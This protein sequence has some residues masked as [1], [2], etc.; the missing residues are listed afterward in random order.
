MELDLGIY[1]SR[2]QTKG[3]K[4]DDVFYVKDA[5]LRKIEDPER[6]EEIRRRLIAVLAP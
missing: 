2:I 4:V 6:L 3:D 5:E 1:V